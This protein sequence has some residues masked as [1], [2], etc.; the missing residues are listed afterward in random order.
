MKSL[1]TESLRSSEIKMSYIENKA[2]WF[3]KTNKY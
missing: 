3:S 2:K 1:R